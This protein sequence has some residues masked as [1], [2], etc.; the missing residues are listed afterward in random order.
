MFHLLDSTYLEILT[1]LSHQNLAVT[2]IIF[3]R[4]VK[5]KTNQHNQYFSKL[6]EIMRAV[7]LD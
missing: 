1:K 2:K 3:Q 4:D 6:L 7:V 5:V